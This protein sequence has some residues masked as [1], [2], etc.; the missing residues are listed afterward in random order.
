MRH[1]GDHDVAPHRPAGSP[2]TL[3]AAAPPRTHID[4]NRDH[5]DIDLDRSLGPLGSRDGFGSLGPLGSRD[6]LGPLGPLG[7]LGPLGPLGSLG[8]L[9]PL[10]SLGPPGSRGLRRLLGPV[11]LLASLGSRHHRPRR[12]S[13]VALLAAALALTIALPQSEPRLLSQARPVPLPSF[14]TGTPIPGGRLNII[15]DDTFIILDATTNTI[16]NSGRCPHGT[17]K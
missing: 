14:C 2:S 16:V 5:V 7:S 13:R 1:A 9:G 4:L 12:A 11:G 3:S 10:G 17:S 15:R 6:P 8:P